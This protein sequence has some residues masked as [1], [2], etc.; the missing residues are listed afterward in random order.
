MNPTPEFITKLH[1]TDLQSAF[2]H[3]T[4]VLYSTDAS[5]YQIMP[6]GVVWPRDTAEVTAAVEIASRHGV[7]ILP[8]G[9]GT[10]LA[11][12][13]VGEA[14]ILDF[15]RYMD[16]ILDV[17]PRQ[18]VARVQPGLPLGRLNRSLAAHGLTFGPDPASADRATIGGVIG[19]NATG[20]HSIIHG[21]TH[22]HLLAAEVIFSN[23][24]KAEFD[25]LPGDALALQERGTHPQ[26]EGAVYSAMAKILAEYAPSI[27]SNYPQT[28]RSVA[29]YNLKLLAEQKTP[30]LAPFLAGTEGTLGI[31]TAVTLNLVPLPKTTHLYLI[32]FDEMRAALES[33]PE[34]LARKPHPSAVE[35]LDKTILDRVRD[36]REYRD[37]LEFIHG[38]PGGVLLVE[39]ND[40]LGLDAPHDF[41]RGLG[42]VVPLTDLVDQDKVWR[43][44][45]VGLGIILSTAGDSKPHSFIEDAAVPV[46]HLADYAL[47]IKRYAGEIGAGETTLYAH[48]SAG[49][50]HIRPMV[51]LKTSQGME[52]M[53]LLAE[54]SLDLVI[55]YGGTIS[56]EHGEGIARGEF[57]ERLF[58]PR[59][60]EAFQEIK[61][62][63]DPDNLLNPGK[64]VNPPR[65]DDESLMRYG[66]NYITPYAPI[67]TAFNFAGTDGFSGAVELCNGAGVCRGLEPNTG[68]MCPSF[69]ATRDEKY[70]TRGR[71]NALRAAMTG[72]L[73]PG[74]MSSQDLYDAL[75]LCLSCQACQSEC[76]SSVDMSKLKAEFLHQYYQEHGV[77]LRAWFF[78]NIEGFSKLAQRFAPL[79]NAVMSSPAQKLLHRLGIHPQ[80]QMPAFARQRF[81]DW[82]AEHSALYSIG[83]TQMESDSQLK[84][85]RP[86]N[87]GGRLTIPPKFGGLGGQ[88]PQI[89]FFHDT[90]MEFNYPHIGEA[91]VKILEKAGFE[92]IVLPQKVDSGRPAVSKGLLKKAQRLAEKNLELLAPYARRGVPIVGC[93]PSSVVMLVK[94]YPDLVPGADAEAVAGTA[95]ILD[96]F[97][98]REAEAGNLDLQ[99]DDTPRKVLF[100]GHCQQKAN[101]GSEWTRKMLELI[102]NCVVE[103]TESGCCGMA[104]AFGYETEHYELSIQIAEMGLAPEVRAAEAETIICAAGTSC[105]EQIAH[106]TG[107]EAVHPVEV[108]AG[109]LRGAR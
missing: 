33:T 20:A 85:P 36:K 98:V 39:Y 87:S 11:G 55:K 30:N 53:R 2:D 76:P 23:G 64:V 13:A 5:I 70:S 10:S 9:A 24:E 99:F 37:L 96:E 35:L 94:E 103:E 79:V 106:T 19:N 15:S 58:G 101:F 51:N 63:F 66:S 18:R 14:L 50:L 46:E 86:P 34:I 21:M 73:G 52:Q 95:M 108:A 82:F 17:D 90:Y 42:D 100:H 69:R 28:F 107:R 6:I 75:D 45:K 48:A 105:R 109:A 54:K 29:G 44:R 77:P 47:E 88:R 84:P 71:A 8:R 89:V 12:Q 104:G 60:T 83:L 57:S 61:K 49:C 78:A 16:G 38:D 41:L 59:L 97:L 25:A 31:I 40:R 43:A 72:E 68:I 67:E 22:D 1:T 56:G 65:M 74:G 27:A 81:T 3:Y 4:R 92:P 7:P 93:E 26:R 102:P 80:R 91:A 62:A 32:H